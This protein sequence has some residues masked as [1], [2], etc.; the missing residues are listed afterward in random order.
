MGLKEKEFA[1]IIEIGDQTVYHWEKE[2]LSLA[3]YICP[4]EL[5]LYRIWQLAKKKGVDINES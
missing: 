2:A 1:A 3:S 5:T 4:G